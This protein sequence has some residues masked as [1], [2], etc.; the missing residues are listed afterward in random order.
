MFFLTEVDTERAN[1]RGSRDP[2]GLVPVWG[3]F[4]RKVVG[5]LT[6]ASTTV[7][8]FTTVLL[9]F[10]FAERI[11]QRHGDSGATRLEIF[12]RFEQLAGFVR[13]LRHDDDQIR[14]ITEIKRRIA[15]QGR[16]RIRIGSA[17][18]LQ[19]LSNQKT[20]GLWGLYTVPSIDSGWLV[21]RDLVLTE[22]ARTLV[23]REY[24][25]I[26]RAEGLGEGRPIEDLLARPSFEFEPDGRHRKIADA[27]AKVLSG[28][29]S[30]RERTDYHHHLVEGGPTGSVT[31]WQPRFARLLEDT[32]SPE[33][34]EFSHNDL[35]RIIRAASRT[36]SDQPLAHQ[37][38]RIRD[39][40]WLLVTMG[41]LFGFLQSR[42]AA[43]KDDLQRALVNAWGETLSFLRPQ[44]IDE[45]QS[46]IG[47]IYGDSGA[48]RRLFDLSQALLEG[49][50]SSAIGLVLAHNQ[51]VMKARHGSEP[52]MQ[53]KKDRLS[54]RYRDATDVS[55]LAPRELATA[56]RSSF[57]LNPLKTVSDQLRS[58]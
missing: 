49:D 40:E 14:G 22:S 10:H 2:L 54:V 35:V 44:A 46:E 27:L 47:R 7:R 5:N 20:Y 18:N 13:K 11:L 6:T 12:M 55:L 37:L 17:T 8:G 50:Y 28:R 48:G 3:A 23:E 15:E 30:S 52:W 21:P 33:D 38:E 16:S 29:L 56:W 1:I 24:L 25:T 45:M 39:L 53:W 9:G 57:Y 41:N 36:S 43:R 26:I 32:L 31:G 19:I 34:G 51:F 42:D 4:G 58:A